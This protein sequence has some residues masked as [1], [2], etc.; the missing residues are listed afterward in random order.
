MSA[1]QL[2]SSG[3]VEETTKK[4]NP[5]DTPKS[6]SSQGTGVLS[7]GGIQPSGTPSGRNTS[8]ANTSARWIA[9]WRR[10]PKRRVDQCAY[11]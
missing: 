2:C 10:A 4:G 7:A 5:T 8:A 3:A 9:A 1:S 6:S 11:R